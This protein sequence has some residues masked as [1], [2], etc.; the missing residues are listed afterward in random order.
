MV[1]KKTQKIIGVIKGL[2]YFVVITL[3]ILFVIALIPIILA[4]AFLFGIGIAIIGLIGCI[5]EVL[6]TKKLSDWKISHFYIILNIVFEI[7]KFYVILLVWIL[8]ILI[9]G[10]T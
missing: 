5:I 3:F 6:T 2:F 4:V 9:K 1:S 8:I 10:N 7:F